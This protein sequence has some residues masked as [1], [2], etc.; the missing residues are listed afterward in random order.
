MRQKNNGIK[1]KDGSTPKDSEDEKRQL[2]RHPS[3]QPRNRHLRPSP[4]HQ[5]G[6]LTEAPPPPEVP[7]IDHCI[8]Q[9][10]QPL[11]VKWQVTNCETITCDTYTHLGKGPYLS[12]QLLQIKKS[13][14]LNNWH[15][16]C[17]TSL[18]LRETVRHEEKV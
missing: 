10:E 16:R 9:K 11:R 2:C 4:V 8:K 18:V 13:D 3:Q 14:P 6:R 5:Q 15:R 17:P 12:K 7:A 1:C